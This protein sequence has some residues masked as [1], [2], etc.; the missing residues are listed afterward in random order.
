MNA[1][2]TLFVANLKMRF[3]EPAVVFFLYAFPLLLLVVFGLMFGHTTA[4]IGEVPVG[5]VDLQLPA[6][7]V[8][9]MATI[10]F[11]QI[12]SS[13]AAQ[14]ELGILR[15]LRAHHLKPWVYILAELAV[16]VVMVVLSTGLLMLAST[17]FFGLQFR[18][19]VLWVFVCLV[20]CSVSLFSIGYL[21]ACAVPSSRLAG[22]I[23]NF[24]FFPM[25]F[26][27]GIA[28]PIHEM[29]EMVGMVGSWSPLGQAVT[30]MQSAWHGVEPAAVGPEMAMLAGLLVVSA[31]LAFRWFR[32]Q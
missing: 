27:S 18:G 23:G 16:N 15:T 3:R 11:Q 12:P 30:L 28:V 29:P 9:A 21:I 14:R 32:W 22:A 1:L 19:S 10:A 6:L 26:L 24:L 7:A 20:F 8:L 5:Y 4:N 17:L 31:V 13:T 2:R 25:M